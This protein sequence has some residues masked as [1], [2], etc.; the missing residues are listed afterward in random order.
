MLLDST[1]ATDA[2]R[3]VGSGGYGVVATRELVRG[4]PALCETTLPKMSGGER[5]RRARKAMDKLQSLCKTIASERKRKKTFLQLHR[6]GKA[7]S[8]PVQSSL[9]S[10]KWKSTCNFQ[11]E[12]TKMRLR[13]P[14]SL[15]SPIR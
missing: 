11:N 7:E 3:Y 6:T 14:N 4:P 8:S 13:P 1:N 5:E 2:K 9:V 12:S 15:L 10:V